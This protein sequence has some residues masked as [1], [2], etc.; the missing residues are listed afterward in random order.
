MLGQKLWVVVPARDEACW[1]EGVVRTMPSFVDHVVVID[2]GSTD[3]T[4]ALAAAAGAQ[5][6]GHA[7]SRGVGAAILSGYRAALSGGADLV[8]V[9]AGDGQ[10]CPKDLC[11]LATPV[12]RG[13]AD[14]AKGDRFHHPD[15]AVRMPWA[16]RVVGRWLSLATGW[17]VGLR[18]LSDSQSGYTVIHRRALLAIDLDHVYAGYGYPNDLLGHL[19]RAEQRVID[20]V[21]RPVYRGEKS[22]LKPRHVARIALLVARAAWRARVT[23]SRATSRRDVPAHPTNA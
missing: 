23:A 14:Y 9:M 22:G 4:A 15:I 12:A 17:A 8:A 16:R 13:E 2:D 3:A 6:I 1:I 18:G 20:V 19:C 5:V 10:M 21:V 11:A 7:V